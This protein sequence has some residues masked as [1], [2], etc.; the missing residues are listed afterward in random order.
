MTM[1][2]ETTVFRPGP[3]DFTPPAP[4]ACPQCA[5]VIVTRDAKVQCPVCGLVYVV[6]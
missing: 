5:T 3:F 2:V 6:D 1:T 4:W